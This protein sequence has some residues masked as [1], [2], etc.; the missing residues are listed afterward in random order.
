MD[1]LK[2]LKYFLRRAGNTEHKDK[3]E[4]QTREKEGDWV[5][6]KLRKE[7]KDRTRRCVEVLAQ[8]EVWVAEKT[9]ERE[10]AAK[11][12]RSK[13]KVRSDVWERKRKGTEF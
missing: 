5:A 7:I 10:K 8:E 9:E 6:A 1:T 13:E 12:R 3:R 4:K 11:K 2:D